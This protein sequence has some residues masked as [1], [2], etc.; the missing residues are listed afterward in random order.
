MTD[1][2]LRKLRRQDLLQ[3]LLAQSR[4]VARQQELGDELRGEYEQQQKTDRRLKN[5]LDEKDAQ[6]ERLKKKLDQK[7]AEIAALRQQV[8][9]LRAGKGVKPEE[10]GSVTEIARHINDIF[11]SAQQ[12]AEAYMNSLT[13]EVPP[14]ELP[15]PE[16]IEEPEQAPVPEPVAEPIPEPVVE[17]APDAEPE[18]PAA[19]EQPAPAPKREQPA[20]RRHGKK[21]PAWVEQEEQKAPAALDRDDAMGI[22]KDLIKAGTA[23]LK[24]K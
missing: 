5:K 17:T 24:K 21:N 20:R 13:G 3:L 4:E 15:E 7:D 18:A 6:L 16:E 8:A 2:E 10:V 14:V 22:A 12:Q 11:Q 23:W 1:K 9:R 19:P